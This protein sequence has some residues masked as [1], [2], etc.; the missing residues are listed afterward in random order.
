MWP[1]RPMT[2]RN[3]GLAAV[4]SV[5]AIV[6]AGCNRS[7]DEAPRLRFAIIPKALGI[8]V[9]DYARIGAEREAKKIG[10]IEVLWR[11]PETV[12]EIR[13]K[14]ILE[15]FIA[16]RVDGIAVSC[17][18]GDLLTDAINR[19]VAAGI[20]VIT[21]DSDA[22][23]SKRLAFYGVNDIE[24]GRALGE[25]LAKLL[26]GKGKVAMLTALG[27]D[28]L[29]KRLDGA[30]ESLAKY[31]GI[32]IVE[33]FDIKDDPVR[34]TEVIASATQRYPDLDGWVSVGG[35]PVFVRSAL[36]PVDPA[37]T[38]VA[39]FDTIPPAPE[40]MKA[41]KV[42][43]LVG[44]KYFG[45]GEESVKLLKQIHDGNPPKQVYQ[46]S[47]M[48]LVTPENVDAYLEQW[49]KWETQ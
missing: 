10:G 37:K 7:G 49:K 35:W 3:A 16:Q 42:Q 17:L 28:N 32:E 34:V 48:D 36:D 23:R 30:K 15:S 21:W 41:G 18:N 43:F 31:P 5:L 39:A 38:K 6:L 33:V 47:E 12:D 9:F 1:D 44:Q 22:P 24:G 29:Q 27:A 46:Y 14:E 25:G 19:A 2:N 4:L 11:G 40:L 26:D 13:Q 45:W 8:P 20:P